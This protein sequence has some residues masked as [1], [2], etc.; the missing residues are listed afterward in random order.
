MR[1]PFFAVL[2]EFLWAGEVLPTISQREAFSDAVIRD[3]QD[4]PP[5]ESKDKQ[6]FDRP[7]ADPADGCESFQD[8]GLGHPFNGTRIG[9]DAGDGFGGDIF[10]GRRFGPGQPSSAQA[11]IGHGEELPGAGEGRSGKEG[12]DASQNGLGSSAVELLMSDRL[13]ESLKRAAPAPDFQLAGT[14]PLDE[15]A[16]D[17]VRQREMRRRVGR[18]NARGF[19][20]RRRGLASDASFGRAF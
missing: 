12:E 7:W 8:F 18:A 14:D 17:L 15:P 6:H 2:E 4:I 13:D 20:R 11:L 3:R 9:D 10:E 5:A 19:K 16:E 1:P